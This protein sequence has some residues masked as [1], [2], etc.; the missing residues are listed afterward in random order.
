MADGAVIFRERLLKIVCSVR[1]LGEV[2]RSLP[3]EV[4]GLLQ[5]T[6]C[7]I[8]CLVPLGPNFR[9][10]ICKA[11]CAPVESGETFA[12]GGSRFAN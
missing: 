1:G 3:N 7:G 9:K 6:V 5:E 10:Y 12:V 4:S 11:I 8:A 2:A